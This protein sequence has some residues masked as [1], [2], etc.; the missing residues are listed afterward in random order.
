MSS[1][2]KTFGK[3]ANLIE[4]YHFWILSM[5]ILSWVCVEKRKRKHLFLMTS[6]PLSHALLL[7]DRLNVLHIE[8]ERF[9]S[10]ILW[11]TK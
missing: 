9:H 8:E 5:L 3:E 6:E 2:V 1:F 10:T 11:F 4:E 7:A